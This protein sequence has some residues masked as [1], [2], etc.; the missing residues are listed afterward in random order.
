MAEQSQ[1]ATRKKRRTTSLIRE[2]IESGDE[3][4]WRWTTFVTYLS[5]Q[6]RRHSL[7]WRA[8]E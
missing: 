7:A 8:A 2:R 5:R 1:L 3:R 4:L 6:S